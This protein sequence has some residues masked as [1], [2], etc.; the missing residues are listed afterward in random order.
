MK[1]IIF[2][3]II[4]LGWALVGSVGMGVALVISLRI[5]TVSTI[6]LD[7]WGEL[8]NGNMAVA[9][10]FAAIVIACAIV[11]GAVIRP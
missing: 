2:D 6:D 11:V 10:V 4:T 1:R 9:V 5:F 7:E 3:Y 8:D